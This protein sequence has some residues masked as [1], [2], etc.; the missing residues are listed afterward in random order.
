VQGR[1]VGALDPIWSSAAF[2]AVMLAASIYS[3]SK[4]N[5]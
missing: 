1:A 2:A 5:F 4:R 3:F